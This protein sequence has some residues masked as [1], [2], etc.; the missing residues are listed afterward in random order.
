MT[1]LKFQGATLYVGCHVLVEIVMCPIMLLQQYRPMRQCFFD[2]ILYNAIRK[3]DYL[4]IILEN[5]SPMKC[6]NKQ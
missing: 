1:F 5:L 2:E 4:E 6:I 3:E